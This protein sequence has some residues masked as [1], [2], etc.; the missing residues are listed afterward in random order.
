MSEIRGKP[1]KSSCLYGTCCLAGKIKKKMSVIETSEVNLKNL[2]KEKH[3]RL[4]FCGF[5][6]KLHCNFA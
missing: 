6:N 2:F 4:D 1:I 3:I 5:V